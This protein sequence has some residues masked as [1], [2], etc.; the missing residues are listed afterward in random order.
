MKFA[1]SVTLRPIRV[2]FLVAPD[3]LALVKRVARLSACLW[4][5]IY[6]PFIPLVS[7]QTDRWQLPYKRMPG[8]TISRR[9]I[10]FFEPDLLVEVTP[11][12]AEALGWS[13]EGSHLRVPRIVSLE[14]FYKVDR[15]RRD[16]ISF[17]AGVDIT[18]VISD[19]YKTDYRYTLRDQPSFGIIQDEE[20]S[21]FFDVVCGRLPTD[22]PLRYISE[23]YKDVFSPEELPSDAQTA[24]RHLT[25][26]LFG[27]LKLTRHQLEESSGHGFRD[28]AFCIF[29]PTDPG[30]VIDYWNFRLVQQRVVPIN[31]QWFAETADQ[32]AEWI[33][34]IHQP[35]P[36]NPSGLKFSSVLHFA[37]SI[38]DD[39]AKEL[40]DQ[41]LSA[42]PRESF[43]YA[44][45]PLL[46]NGSGRGRS[47][48][49][50]KILV[51][52]ATV[53]F[54]EEV[55]PGTSVK[56]PAP[57]P[58]FANSSGRHADASWVNVIK[59]G[60]FYREETP[61]KV[62]PSNLW[63]P[64]YPRLARGEPFHIGREGW[65]LLTE[66]SIGYSLL[67]VQAGREA[68]VGWLK[69]KGL[70]AR[71]SEEGEIA[72]QVITAAG[73]IWSSG[74][75]A[76]VDTIQL[77][78]EMAEN[79]SEINH[80][81]KRIARSTPDRAKPTRQ[82]ENHFKA[83]ETRSFGYWNRLDY[84]LKRSVFRAGLGVRCPICH[85]QNW[86]DLDSISSTPKCTRCL[87]TFDV[88][89]APA[90]L[91]EIDW[92]YRVVGPFAAPDYARGAY[93]V[94]LTLRTL[95]GH[96]DAEMTWSTGL[97]LQQLN[98]EIDFVAWHRAS[99]MLNEEPDEP[100]VVVGEVK[101][102]GLNSFSV[103][104]VNDLKRVAERF[105]GSIMV[106]ST[107]RSGEQLTLGEIGRLRH[108]A[109][110]GRRSF[111]AGQPINPLVIFTGTEL[112]ASHGISMAWKEIDGREPHSAYDFRELHTLADLT[113]ERY[114]GLKS[115]W[116]RDAS[117]QVHHTMAK[118][119]HLLKARAAALVA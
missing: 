66:Y 39:R 110:W 79:H 103:D 116:A 4:G 113:Q 41:F 71:P 109:L 9:Y 30:D 3:D 68:I 62:Y 13:A 12:T 97:K 53:S 50:S 67:E 81:G 63:S 8:R 59:P 27:P 100:L 61:A 22:E 55:K 17:S 73:G 2:G 40:V 18:E 32:I 69:T 119:L 29:D 35:I 65:I 36:G 33:Q 96:H 16:R 102:F 48:Q 11:G 98:C 64:Q 43:H 57:A 78:K 47:R 85:Y 87:N 51:S 28:Q 34:A 72:A 83:R 76:D 49:E 101:S 23:A 38:S 24:L 58:S 56:I 105:P 82:V 89:Q 80:K 94:A 54:D 106:M 60:G 14:D 117:E 111:H 93:A 88:S 15:D 21:A 26:K 75:F 37:S 52:A 107:L 90:D 25:G 77:L 74:M 112:F 95:A 84:F 10:D 115:P 31:V 92:Y 42:L 1:G 114:L 108:L 104:A 91:K 5:G 86:Y 20:N 99:P 118:I 6:N 44:R 46:W 70:D 19:L 45:I 7:E